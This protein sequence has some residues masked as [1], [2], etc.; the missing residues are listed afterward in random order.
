MP[1]VIVVGGG[2]AG[3]ACAAE[4][5]DHDVQVTLIDRHNYTQFQPLLYQVASSQLPAEDVAR[6]LATAFKGQSS[7]TTVTS[8]I[9]GIDP[10]TRTVTTMDGDRRADHQADYL[11]IAAGS[12]PNFFG[13]PGAA[14]HSFPLYS[15]RDARRLRRHLQD[16]LLMLCDPAGSAD[17]YT[18]IICGG[19]PT[20]VE[21]AGALVELFGA[22][23]DQGKLQ[24]A[25]RVRLVDHGT[26]LLRP[27]TDK[28]HEYARD[29]L[30]EKGVQISFG[31]AVSGVQADTVT[32]SDGST[33]DTDTVIWAGGI[34]GAPL[35]ERAGITAGRGGR[36]DV[37]ADLTV[38]GHPDVYAV[39]DVA[40]IPGRDGHAL[41]QLGSVALQSG[42]WAAKNIHAQVKGEDLTPFHYHD[43][44][45]MAMIGRNTAVA[46]IGKHRHHLEGPL[47]F[48]SWLGLHA[49]LLSGIHSRVDAFL[50]WAD[51]YF[52]HARAADLEL[53]DSVGRIAWADD[54][55]DRPKL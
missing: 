11:V 39:G 31:I 36:I 16:R 54:D 32:L 35:V 47:A 38:P 12:Q 13:V 5:A 50:N 21:T 46:E 30:T 53:E 33:V 42:T 37:A 3:V 18:V 29:K 45:I 26:A 14:E 34:S 48:V 6:P 55:A 25:A 4:L 9:T 8:E 24:C 20:G 27:F 51:D 15:V 2:M 41:P 22:L 44:G 10:A 49:V 40:N 19:G 52:H 7:V 23:E 17:P 43:K 1:S 28:S